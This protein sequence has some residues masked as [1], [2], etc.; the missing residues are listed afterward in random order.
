M[1]DRPTLTTAS[2]A[3]AVCEAVARWCWWEANDDG[4]EC[5]DNRVPTPADLADWLP[6]CP[7][8]TRT[9]AAAV[10]VDVLAPDLD[11][12]CR[13]TGYNREAMRALAWPPACEWTADTGALLARVTW[14]A[15]GITGTVALAVDLV[16]AAWRALSEPRP[17]PP[18]APLVAAWQR[19]APV[20]VEPERRA[21][22][23]LLPTLQV[24]GPSVER[25]R[26]ARLFGGLLD[27]RGATPADSTL[28]LW[29]APARYRVPLLDLSEAAGAPLRSTGKGAPL[30]LRLL[31]HAVLAVGHEDRGLPVVRMAVR[32]GDLLDG[33]YPRGGVRPQRRMAQHWP[34][35]EAALM[36]L[37][38]YVVPDADDGRWFIAAL[39]RMPSA[40]GVVPASMDAPVV[41][42]V[43]LPP[44]WSPNGPPVALPWLTAAGVRSGPLYRA[45]IAAQT[46]LWQPG[47]T[48]RPVPG[49]RGRWGWSRNPADFPVLTVDDL[50]ALAFGR[51][52][53]KNRTRAELV[54]PWANLPGAHVEAD[55][56]DPRTGAVGW[57]LLPSV[58]DTT[59]EKADTTGEPDD[60]TGEPDDTT[61]ERQVP[62]DRL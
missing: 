44:S 17:D 59:G 7:A 23:R 24:V 4:A 52:D 27:G 54:A 10:L 36:R 19:L 42:D 28:P 50:R 29:P 8:E 56:T 39:R 48:R 31:V 58:A 34:A 2:T 14:T 13:L 15:P 40:A 33:L 37:R 35:I 49:A 53:A 9:T 16:H 38:D 30:D 11:T 26:G 46:L 18:L 55:A 25:D 21:D 41:I 22:R 47:R 61:G 45:Y 60:T 1:P 20:S 62:E 3:A 12:V 32:V 43:S 51:G 57:R 5:P 6:E